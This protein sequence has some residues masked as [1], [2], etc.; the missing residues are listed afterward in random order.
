M[1]DYCR[2]Y[3]LADWYWPTT[4]EKAEESSYLDEVVS[5]GMSHGVPERELRLLV[6]AG[7]DAFD[8]E[9]LLFDP[10]LRQSCVQEILCGY[11]GC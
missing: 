10:H 8:L 3:G 5:Y 4:S 11:G 2:Y 1:R 7:Y 6:A 9:E